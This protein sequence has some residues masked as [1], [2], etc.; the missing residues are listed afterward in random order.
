MKKPALLF[1]TALLLAACNQGNKKTIADGADSA[2]VKV[3]EPL[4]KKEV[5]SKI[6]LLGKIAESERELFV[7]Q[8][9]N[10]D[11]AKKMIALYEM[12][13]QN[14]FKDYGCADFLFKA[15]EL[16]ENINQPYRAIGFYTKCYE[17]YPAYKFT[18]LC[19]FRMANLYDF[20]LNNYIK[21]KALYLEVKEKYP[22]TQ[23]AND[24]DAA[25]A[26]M[27]KSDQEMIKE[28]EKKNKV[29]K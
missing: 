16:S 6:E 19:L 21:A 20:K 10:E 5:P 26:M 14:Y 13:Y 28:F 8:E 27:G 2:V 9:L 7:S 25:I 3:P 4:A 23:L 17:E 1:F 12:Y 11:K 15:G 24:A 29:K 18:S 22:K